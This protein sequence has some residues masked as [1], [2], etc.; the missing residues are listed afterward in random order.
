MSLLL[1]PFRVLI[2]LLTII[3]G[4]PLAL[5]LSF[6]P[7]K[8]HG[9]TLTAWT[10]T[11]MARIFIWAMPMRF[12]C[13]ERQRFLNHDG[14][15][16]PNH[17]SYLDIIGPM[18][19]RP[20]RFLAMAEVADYPFIGRLAKAIGTIFVKR[21]DKES[22]Q[23]AREDLNEIETYPPVILFPEGGID[24]VESLSTFRY[25]AFEICANNEIAYMPAALIYD[26]FDVAKWGEESMFAAGWRLAKQAKPLKM[27]LVALRTVQTT[28]D[29]N[30]RELA[31]ETH[32]SIASA[33][34]QYGG[35][36][37]TVVEEGL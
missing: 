22:R 15:I 37:Y 5:L 6:L 7:I 34:I 29:D 1:A 30:P 17:D 32:G 11:Y 14:F 18:S 19:V 25:G 36:D 3:F 26:P 16:F 20:M 12:E 31:L 2:V 21:E 27:R 23:K 35:S 4:T 13:R 9:S 24:Q 28:K 10:A 8:R 33:L